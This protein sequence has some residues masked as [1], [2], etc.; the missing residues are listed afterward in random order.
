VTCVVYRLLNS[1]EG[2]TGEMG[3]EFVHCLVAWYFFVVRSVFFTKLG[4]VMGC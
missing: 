4:M 1:V 3:L 2:E